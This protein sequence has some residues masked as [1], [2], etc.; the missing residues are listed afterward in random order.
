MKTNNIL[1]AYLRQNSVIQALGPA[2]ILDRAE[3][4]EN[5]TDKEILDK[6]HQNSIEKDFYLIIMFALLI[7]VFLII[8]YKLITGIKDNTVIGVCMPIIIT[9]LA[10]MHRLWRDKVRSGQMIK[11]LPLLNKEDRL[12]LILAIIKD[13]KEFNLNLKDALQWFSSKKS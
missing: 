3:L 11:V 6:L 9:I 13:N 4:S 5:Q 1:T 2:D 7:I 10:V 12:K 8:V